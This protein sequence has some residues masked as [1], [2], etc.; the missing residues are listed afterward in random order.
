MTHVRDGWPVSALGDEFLHDVV[1]VLHDVVE[2]G[3]RQN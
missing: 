1:E 3:T 2:G